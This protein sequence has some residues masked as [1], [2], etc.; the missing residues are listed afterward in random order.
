MA[1]LHKR[2]LKDGTRSSSSIPAAHEGVRNPMRAS[3]PL[4]DRRWWSISR[5]TSV[6]YGAEF[7]TP[8][9]QSTIGIQVSN[10]RSF[11]GTT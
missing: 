2:R 8:I 11:P 4:S 7:S 1:L 9:G 6:A 10:D 3:T 5:Q